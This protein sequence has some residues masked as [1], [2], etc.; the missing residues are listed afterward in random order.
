VA[1]RGAANV[2][3]GGRA[4]AAWRAAGDAARVGRERPSDPRGRPSPRREVEPEVVLPA[5]LVEE[6]PE[7]NVLRADEGLEGEDLGWAD[8]EPWKPEEW[9]DEGLVRD[10][11]EDAVQRGR[12]SEPRRPAKR[13]SPMAGTEDEEV[14]EAERR[15]ARADAQAADALESELRNAVGA[16]KA[17]RFEQRMRD[18][19]AAFKRGRYDE[20]RRILRPMV[21]QAPRVAALRELYGLTLYR[22]ERWRAAA[23]EL[24][25]FRTLTGGVE[26]HPVLADC[27]RALGR[28]ADVEQ[29][30]EELAAASPSSAL[31]AEGRIVAAGDLADQSRI[32]EAIKLLEPGVRPARRAKDHHLRVAYALADLYERAGDLPRARELFERVAAS[33]PDFVDVVARLR[34]LG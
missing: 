24:E 13:W 18:A 31:V 28:H 16:T 23:N 21:D 7:R 30:W 34:A 27:Y 4:S 12:R 5:N 15:E 19:G 17:A 33:D 25:V 10:E 6:T 8:D 32:D 2:R 9:I 22:L 20:A 29:L 3:D 14:A 1:R 11:A 26:Q